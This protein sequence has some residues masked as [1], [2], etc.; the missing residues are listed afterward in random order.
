MKNVLPSR[1]QNK[2]AL[3]KV[4]KASK[5]KHT[6]LSVNYKIKRKGNTKTGLV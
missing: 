1:K 5:N 4:L 3:G 2:K 6:K